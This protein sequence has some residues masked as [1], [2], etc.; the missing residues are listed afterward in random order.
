VAMVII[1][2]MAVM[3]VDIMV[4]TVVIIAVVNMVV[5]VLSW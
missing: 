4:G 3:A 1:I 2:S 5:V